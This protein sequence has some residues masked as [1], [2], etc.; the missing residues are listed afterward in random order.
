KRRRQAAEARLGV[1]TA[2]LASLRTLLPVSAAAAALCLL[3][4]L[5]PL[6]RAR[7]LWAERQVQILE[8]GEM[9]YYGLAEQD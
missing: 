8:Q 2:W 1:V 4:T 3:I 9:H 7:G 5:A 6:A